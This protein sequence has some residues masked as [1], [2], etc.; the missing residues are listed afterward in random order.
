MQI[1]GSKTQLQLIQ[2]LV[3]LFICCESFFSCAHGGFSA[4]TVQTANQQPQVCTVENDVM[5]LGFALHFLD[6]CVL[7]RDVPD[8]TSA[9][10]SAGLLSIRISCAWHC[11]FVH[12]L[13]PN[14]VSYSQFQRTQVLILFNEGNSYSVI[15]KKSRVKLP[16]VKKWLRQARADEE[17]FK[18]GPHSSRE[19]NR[20]AN[21]RGAPV[22]SAK[23]NL[24]ALGKEPARKQSGAPVLSDRDRRKIKKDMELH[25]KKGSRK[26][27]IRISKTSAESL[28]DDDLADRQG[29]PRAAAVPSSRP[30][31]GPDAC[32]EAATSGLRKGTPSD[33]WTH[34]LAADEVEAPTDG[35]P[36]LHNAV[37]WAK[38]TAKV[39]PSRRY[40]VAGLRTERWSRSKSK[41]TRIL[42]GIK[43]CCKP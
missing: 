17:Y 20:R 30:Q 42:A 12:R 14:M 34:V 19:G 21:R 10:G 23:K 31:T 29:G 43:S 24:T 33:D 41:V 13:Y 6:L 32:T 25:P 18:E 3:M 27:S 37:Y 28:A 15:A 38:A 40:F 7:S 11:H 36:N 22:L 8:G 1:F 9:V 5:K 2:T 39:A 4:F 26:A 35:S 16:T